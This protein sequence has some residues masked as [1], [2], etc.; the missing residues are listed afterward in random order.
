MTHLVMGS[1]RRLV[2]LLLAV[3]LCGAVGVRADDPTARGDTLWVEDFEQFGTGAV[4]HTW[5][6]LR[7]RELLPVTEQIMSEGEWFRIREEDGRR[8]ARVHTEGEAIQIIHP[9]SEEFPW[10]LES[11][12]RLRWDWRVLEAP[13]EANERESGRNDTAAAVYVTFKINWLGIPRSIKYTYSSSLPVG[14][15]V[16]FTGLKVLVV[17]SG[18]DGFGEWL[19]EE[20]NLVEDYRR[21]YGGDPPNEPLSIALWS[22]S[23]SVGGTTTADFDEIV[24]LPAEDS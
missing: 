17:A 2:S 16:S 6:F 20:R 19:R 21:V 4:P 3:T 13:L 7:D 1:V 12:P 8:F 24:L 10:T 23:D 15:V 9:T 11:H 14:S 5:K 18:P 22:D